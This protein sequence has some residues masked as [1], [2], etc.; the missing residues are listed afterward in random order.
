MASGRKA[1]RRALRSG[2]GGRAAQ[3]QRTTW[4]RQKYQSKKQQIKRPGE[5]SDEISYEIP[6]LPDA[7]PDCFRMLPEPRPKMSKKSQLL[8]DKGWGFKPD[9]IYCVTLA[10]HAQQRVI[11]MGAL[12]RAHNFEVC[13]P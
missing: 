2:R 3:T 12:L 6:K 13:T 9:L 1:A 11:L 7:L 4:A 5:I 8:P 10:Q